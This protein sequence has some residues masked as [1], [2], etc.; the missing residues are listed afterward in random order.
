M[1]LR[2]PW[3]WEMDGGIDEHCACGLHVMRRWSHFSNTECSYSVIVV[4]FYVICQFFF[5]FV[6][7]YELTI[8]SAMTSDCEN[9]S[10]A[11]G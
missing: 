3:Q 2:R 1:I 10:L 5:P 4:Y 6:C 11:S 8:D 7:V 9:I